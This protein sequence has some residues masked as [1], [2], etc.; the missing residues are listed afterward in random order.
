MTLIHQI[1]TVMSTKE[2]AVNHRTDIEALKNLLKEVIPLLVENYDK[3]CQEYMDSAI[4]RGAFEH[5]NGRLMNAQAV[6]D[7]GSSKNI[8]SC[9][10]ILA[11]VTIDLSCILIS[12]PDKEHLL[13]RWWCLFALNGYTDKSEVFDIPVQ[14]L[15]HTLEDRW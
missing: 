2:K 10:Q 4:P 11:L 9:F 1:D 8:D 6:L 13:S 7:H 15:E 3:A 14:A 5:V 12:Y